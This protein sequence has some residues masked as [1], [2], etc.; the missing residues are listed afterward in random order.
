MRDDLRGVVVILVAIILVCATIF[1]GI[2]A[3]ELMG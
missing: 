1:I 3:T 2:C